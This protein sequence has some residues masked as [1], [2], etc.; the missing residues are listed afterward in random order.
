MYKFLKTVW[1]RTSYPV[2]IILGFVV[3]VQLAGCRDSGTVGSVGLPSRS[4][5][6]NTDTTQLSDLHT[7][8]LNAYSGDRSYFSAGH[9]QDP[10]FGDIKSIGL[11]KPNLASNNGNYFFD[12][13]TQMKLKLIINKESV[14]GDPSAGEKFKLV[15][16]AKPWRGQ[17]WRLKNQVQLVQDS[18]VGSFT[19]T[20]NDSV[21][22]P[23]SSH[24][25][26]KYGN[27]FNNT[28]STRNTDYRRNFYGFALVPQNSNKIL[29]FDPGNSYF[30]ATN[31][32]VSTDTTTQRDSLHISP[33]GW[34]YNLNRKEASDSISG[35]TKVYNTLE[36]TLSFN[37]DFSSKNI[38]PITL[39]KAELV[40]YR[41]E[42]QY[43]NSIAQAGSNVERPKSGTL[44]LHLANS[45]ELPQSIDPGSPLISATYNDSDKAYHFN[46]TRL[47]KS[48]SLENIGSNMSFYI[49]SGRNDGV[50][51]SNILFNSNAGT[52]APKIII[53]STNNSNQ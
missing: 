14:Y 9:F 31:I 22:V 20:S 28:D 11:I 12:Q 50:I 19:V 47:I 13:K 16:I 26:N 10:L 43:N 38:N 2:S 25:V 52:K 42:L 34:A 30:I 18:V 44:Y 29:A 39:S 8:A 40:I 32:K 3:L 41:D 27:Y 46:L 24:F 33:M 21:T 17:S 1:N 45:G 4:S 7:N 35:T 5:E 15:E 53:T 49:K 48:G 36:K 51:R 37:Y 23:L 6:I